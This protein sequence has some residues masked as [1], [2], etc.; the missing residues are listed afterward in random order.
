MTRAVFVEALAPRDVAAAPAPAVGVVVA[1]PPPA[2]V[3]EQ[4]PRAAAQQPAAVDVTSTLPRVP[5][6]AARG[7]RRRRTRH[8][9]RRR[10]PSPKQQHRRRRRHHRR[11]AAPAP[12]E[13]LRSADRVV[14]QQSAGAQTSTFRT[15]WSMSSVVVAAPVTGAGSSSLVV[16]PAAGSAT[17]SSLTATPAAG[18]STS[19]SVA[20]PS[21]S[22]ADSQI[23]KL[24]RKV[25]A[26]SRKFVGQ[27]HD[28][29]G[30]VPILTTAGRQ[31]RAMLYSCNGTHGACNQSRP[32]GP[33]VSSLVVLDYDL[34]HSRRPR[35]C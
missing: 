10:S 25:E 7:R 22:T 16:T 32:F 19:S 14:D 34:T 18:S 27:P 35:T 8:G 5:M 13:A 11:A 1:A 20:T 29:R 24:Y 30:L 28:N 17:S 12:A 2:V 9:D 3:I 26:M 6:P 33:A 21:S 23:N 31:N 15:A 4:A